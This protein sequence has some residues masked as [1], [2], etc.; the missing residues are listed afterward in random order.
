MPSLALFASG[1]GSNVQRIVEYFSGNPHIGID[2]ILTNNPRA[3]VLERARNLKIPSVV[4]SRKEFYGSNYVPDILAVQ[5]ISH[6]VL[7]GF[8]W[9]IPENIL[10]A[11]QGKILNIH[12]ALLP[13]YGGKGMYGTRV[14]QAVLASG[15]PESGI[16]IHYVNEKYDDG[17]IIFQSRC[18]VI[19]GETPETLAE[20][21]H[22]LEYRHFPEIIES[23][24]K[25]S[26]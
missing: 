13:K 24:V 21:I 19:P 23:V 15:D 16:T 6:I 4:F 18:P 7:A 9:L 1:N 26:R 22:Q 10:S 11:F 12:P 3:Y 25:K 2:L 8:L 20:K 5:N 14:H 17:Q